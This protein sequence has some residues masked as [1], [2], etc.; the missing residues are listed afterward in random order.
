VQS[1]PV[2][3]IGSS[4]EGLDIAKAIQANLADSCECEIWNQGPFGLSEGSLESLVN[5]LDKFDF[6]VLAITADDL[7][8]IRG[9]LHQ[10]PRDNVLFELG[11]FM[12][13]LGKERVFGL[14]LAL[15]R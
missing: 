3:F 13:R 1:K 10:T 8:Q 2:I 4:K 14:W 15:S 11:L 9:Q 5:A 7:S 12:G 6:A